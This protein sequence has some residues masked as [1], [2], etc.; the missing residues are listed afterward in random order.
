MD[1][2]EERAVDRLLL[3]RGGVLDRLQGSRQ[4]SQYE[5]D[6]VTKL[7]MAFRNS[8]WDRGSSGAPRFLPPGGAASRP[9]ESNRLVTLRVSGL[10]PLGPCSLPF[11]ARDSAMR[12][13]ASISAR[14]QCVSISSSSSSSHSSGGGGGSGGGGRGA[15]AVASSLEAAEEPNML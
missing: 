3:L 13:L 10:R 8:A 12:L 7:L 14:S 4:S 11:L 5:E 9:G 1:Q 15:S 6:R 2:E